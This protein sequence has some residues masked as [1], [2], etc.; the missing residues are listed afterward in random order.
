MARPR[1]CG[2]AER[3]V[4]TIKDLSLRCAQDRPLLIWLEDMQWTDVETRNVI[5]NLT[6]GIAG[7][8]LL[9]ILTCRPEYEHKAISERQFMSLHVDPLG[10]DAADELVRALLGGTEDTAELR[11]HIVARTEGTPLFIEETIRALVESGALRMR[12]GRCELTRR[13]PEIRIPETVQSVI[14]AR[15]D[16]LSPKR[17]TLLQIASVI[18]SEI[19]MALLREV[20]DLAEPE[21]Q[22]LLAELKAAQFL[23]EI[24]NVSSQLKFRHVLVHEVTYSS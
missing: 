6:E 20:V 12:A 5:D 7:S 21:L 15:I 11:R 24:P 1:P 4:S 19:P 2:T 22:K 9:V 16:S 8:R 23:Y 10:T 17:K 14:A 18:G 13:I 3:I